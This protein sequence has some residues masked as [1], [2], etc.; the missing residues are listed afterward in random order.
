[1]Y[2]C[3]ALLGITLVWFEPT[4]PLGWLALNVTTLFVCELFSILLHEAAHVFMAKA[5]GWKPFRVQIGTGKTVAEKRIFGVVWQIDA[6]PFGG[7]TFN[8]PLDE[9][10]LR[11]RFFLIVAAGMPVHI[12]LAAVALWAGGSWIGWLPPPVV[13]GPQ[14][15][16]MLLITNVIYLV[17]NL[18]P[19][20]ATVAGYMVKTDGALMLQVLF[21]FSKIRESLLVARPLLEA[22]ELR[23]V[24]KY[25][26]ANDF[27]Q[28]AAAKIPDNV[29]I[30]TYLGI[31]LLDLQRVR[32]AGAVFR[33]ILAKPTLDET[34]KGVML[35]NLAWS[36][37]VADDPTLLPEADEMSARANDKVGWHPAVKGTRGS[38]LIEL[39]RMDEG[40]S[41]VSAAMQ[42]QADP[43]SK[44][45][46]AC[47]LAIGYARK[48]EWDEAKRY[49]EIARNLDPDCILLDR[50]DREFANKRETV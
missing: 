21:Q 15:A 28:E 4:Q 26:E 30:L 40:L 50:V 1:M 43:R 33:R 25:N 22:I 48:G 16:S 19:G 5:V 37:L 13:Q 47:Y 36:D 11:W 8:A 34:T 27:L 18:I 49:R 31:N 45:S 17:A 9:R 41:L 6:A 46:N 3:Q 23:K 42:A 24:K 35:N 2:G 10:G 20:K 14:W 12:V 44:A 29:H 39:R 7:V 32:D 38:V